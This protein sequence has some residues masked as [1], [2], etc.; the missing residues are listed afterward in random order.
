MKR[1]QAFTLIELL[2]VIA[3]IAILAAILF[4]VFAQAKRA[5]KA[6]SCLSGL[7]Q[8]ALAA[9]MYANDYEDQWVPS[10][11]YQNYA[12]EGKNDGNDLDWW[13][14]ILQPYV[15]NRPIVLCPERKVNQT[16][17]AQRD[18]WFDNGGTKIKLTSYAVNDMNYFY[19]FGNAAENQWNDE[20]GQHSGFQNQDASALANQPGAS[21]N[22]SAIADPSGTIWL[23]DVPYNLSEDP[24]TEIWADW[25]IDWNPQDW[26][27][28]NNSFKLHNGGFNASF[29]DS[30]A[31]WRHDGASR[32]CDF[33]IQDDCATTPPATP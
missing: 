5:A 13:D 10:F 22:G 3:I 21:I 4:P 16:F 20:A 31:K 8:W 15:K 33:T 24:V 11:L 12:T 9:P 1:S 2:V 23:Q 6:S 17:G 28:T 32:V 14:D 27:H 29:A 25:D 26:V 19:T 18:R 7:K 30:H